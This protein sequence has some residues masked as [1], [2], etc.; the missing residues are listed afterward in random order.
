MPPRK[1]PQPS[2]APLAT[3]KA[4]IAGGA[5]QPAHDR[6]ILAPLN[7]PKAAPSH[8]AKHPI[9]AMAMS[10][11]G[12]RALGFYGKVQIGKRAFTGHAGKVNALAF[13]A[14]ENFLVAA[15]GVTGLRGEAVLWNLKTGQRVCTFGEGHRD[16]LYGAVF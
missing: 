2:A 1:E 14:D 4:W 10:R 7:V 5:K 9:T 15:T 8:L 3:L 12:I 11:G 6:S 13:S 16:S